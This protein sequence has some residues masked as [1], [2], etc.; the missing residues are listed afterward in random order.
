[1]SGNIYNSLSNF[2][3]SSLSLAGATYT[4]GRH[5]PQ[6]QGKGEAAASSR[7]IKAVQITAGVG[8]LVVHPVWNR[9]G[10]NYTIKLDSTEGI[11]S[12]IPIFDYIVEAGTT[13]V[14]ANVILFPDL[15]RNY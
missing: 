11:Q 1:M 14:L 6:F 15:G 7:R 12:P 13:A 10:V 9:D 4:A 8:D 5:Y 3:D 2:P